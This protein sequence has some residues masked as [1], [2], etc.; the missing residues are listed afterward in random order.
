MSDDVKEVATDSQE[1]SQNETNNINIEDLTASL[2]DAMSVVEAQKSQISGLDRR[3]SELTNTISIKDEQVK[4]AEQEKL[5]DMERLQL[6]VKSM[7]EES[8]KDKIESKKANNRAVAIEKMSRLSLDSE[9][10]EKVMLDFDFSVDDFE[11]KLDLKISLIQSIKD[12]MMKDFATSNG[13]RV[14]NTSASVEKKEK[15]FFTDDQ[16][17]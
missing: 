14:V 12:Q 15:G 10:V 11:S 9:I 1:Q 8:L 4:R 7:R 3:V 16:F 13:S 17:K 6:E 5:S 2:K